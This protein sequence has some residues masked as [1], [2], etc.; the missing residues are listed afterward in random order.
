MA[1]T[2]G[3]L[4]YA[5]YVGEFYGTPKKPVDDCIVNGKDVI[6]EIEV[7]G[8][9]QVMALEPEAV[10]IFIV[11]PDMEELER[12]LRKRGTDSEEKLVA[13][14]ERAH[15]E[16]EE[17]NRYKHIVVNDDVSR[18]AEEILAIIKE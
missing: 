6:L 4:E 15:T 18:A 12:R 16:L 13:R 10:T 14:L 17:R 9:R 2:G 3:F 1:D 7:Q 11:P 5:A 8:A